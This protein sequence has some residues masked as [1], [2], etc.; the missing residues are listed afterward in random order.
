MIFYYC[1]Q[2]S[3]GN[4]IPEMIISSYLFLQKLANVIEQTKVRILKYYI[5]CD[6]LL[7]EA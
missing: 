4:T 5:I 1:P 7:V 6:T 3:H 2:N